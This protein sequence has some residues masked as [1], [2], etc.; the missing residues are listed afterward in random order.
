M[1]ADS[2]K[3]SR[4]Q[5]PTDNITGNSIETFSLPSQAISCLKPTELNKTKAKTNIHEM[6]NNAREM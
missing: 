3:S 1:S 5:H 4:I 2:K 6:A